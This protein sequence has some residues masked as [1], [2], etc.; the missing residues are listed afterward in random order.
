MERYR[1]EYS[2]RDIRKAKENTFIVRLQRLNN[3]RGYLSRPPT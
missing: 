3:I 1:A 2:E